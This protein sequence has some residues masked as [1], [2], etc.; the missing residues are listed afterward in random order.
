MLHL[1]FVFCKTNKKDRNRIAEKKKTSAVLQFKF[2]IFFFSVLVDPD[3][4]LNRTKTDRIGEFTIF[5]SEK[6]VGE[7]EFYLRLKHNCR[8]G[9]VVKVCYNLLFC[10]TFFSD[11]FF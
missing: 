7:V 6:E 5:G 11:F 2:C 4:F 9:Q 3:D 8:D 10:F 1:N